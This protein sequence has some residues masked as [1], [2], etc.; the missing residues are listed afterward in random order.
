MEVAHTVGEPVILTTQSSDDVPFAVMCV[1]YL[2]YSYT[3]SGMRDFETALPR[4][5]R[6]LATRRR[7][8]RSCHRPNAVETPT[9]GGLEGSTPPSVVSG[10]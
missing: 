1:R 6:E 5:L 3:P 9:H 7:T 8:S 10:L 4:A 2:P